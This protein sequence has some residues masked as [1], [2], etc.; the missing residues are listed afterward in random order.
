MI[1]P[2]TE[3]EITDDKLTITVDEAAKMINVGKNLML[4]L[5]KTD[6]FPAVRFERKIIINKRQFIQWFDDLTSGKINI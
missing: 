3:R 5:V 1:K 2:N 6:R 4:E